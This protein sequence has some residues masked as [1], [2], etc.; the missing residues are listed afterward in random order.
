MYCFFIALELYFNHSQTHLSNQ[1]TQVE[2][3]FLVARELEQFPNVPLSRFGFGGFSMGAHV[4]LWCGL[5]LPQPCA[6]VVAM[7]GFALGVS[8]FVVSS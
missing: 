2:V 7:S 1:N 5:Q 3:L 4:A 8:E 6:C